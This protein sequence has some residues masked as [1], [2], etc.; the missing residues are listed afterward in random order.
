MR[1]TPSCRWLRW[2]VAP[3]A[4]PAEGRPPE[5]FARG[6]ERP[7]PDGIRH[8]LVARVRREIEAGIYDTEEK[9]QL[10]QERLLSRLFSD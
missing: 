6:G 2:R 9:W 4:R 1:D 7:A 5:R 8:G 3:A 10:A